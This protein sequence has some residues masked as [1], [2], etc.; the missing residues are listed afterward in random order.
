MTE[1]EVLKCIHKE[2]RFLSKDSSSVKQVLQWF[3]D[4]DL[5]QE[6]IKDMLLVSPQLLTRQFFQP[7]HTIVQ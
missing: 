7:Y 5:T 3:M 2:P 4:S 1:Q 6:E